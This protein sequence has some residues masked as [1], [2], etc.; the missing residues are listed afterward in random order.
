[1]FIVDQIAE[2]SLQLE[3]DLVVMEAVVLH[4][5]VPGV[6]G[7]WALVQMVPVSREGLPRVAGYQVVVRSEEHSDEHGV[8]SLWVD[9]YGNVGER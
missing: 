1:M 4:D 5:L 9:N 6:T 8:V 3:G 2:L 7:G